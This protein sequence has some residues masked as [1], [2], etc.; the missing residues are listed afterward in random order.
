[1]NLIPIEQPLPPELE[2]QRQEILKQLDRMRE[3]FMQ[4]SKPYVDALTR[5]EAVRPIPKYIV[6]K[7]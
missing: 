1:M 2:E 5:I 7:D 6:M 3:E 4:A